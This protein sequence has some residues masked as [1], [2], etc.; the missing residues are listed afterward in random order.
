MLPNV[1]HFIPKPA[2]LRGL[3]PALSL[4]GVNST[5]V[6]ILDTKTIVI[7]NFYFEGDAPGAW[8]M[9]GKSLIPSLGG[10]IVPIY[11]SV[12]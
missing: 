3:T 6:E 5:S 7:K 12:K 8:F 4:K 9:V 11:N 10:Q 2:T 1:Q